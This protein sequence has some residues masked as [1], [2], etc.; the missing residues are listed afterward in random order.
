MDHE[1]SPGEL[2]AVVHLACGADPGPL[3]RTE[4]LTDVGLVGLDLLSAVTAIE[5]RFDITL[6]ADLL[7]ALETVDDLLH[8]AAVARGHRRP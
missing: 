1:V 3:A 2:R 4:R 5:D 6:P 7:P 8:F